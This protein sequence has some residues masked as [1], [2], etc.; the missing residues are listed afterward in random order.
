MAGSS[1]NA[2]LS[3]VSRVRS[4]FSPA[5]SAGSPRCRFLVGAADVMGHLYQRMTA[6]EHY[7]EAAKALV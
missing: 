6:G 4:H 1:R 2:A 7:E 5:R 3:A